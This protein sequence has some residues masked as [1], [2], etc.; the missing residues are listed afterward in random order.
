MLKMVDSVGNLAF[1]ECSEA[2]AKYLT[3]L[4]NFLC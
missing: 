4:G 3:L 1:P 2:G